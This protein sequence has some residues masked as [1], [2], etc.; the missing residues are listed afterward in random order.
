MREH[1]KIRKDYVKLVRAGDQVGAQKILV[2][3][4]NRKENVPEILEPIQVVG[5]MDEAMAEENVS[6]VKFNSL[7]SLTKIN[8]IGKKTVSDIKIM[9]KDLDSL[10]S[11]IILDNVALRDDIVK[12]LREE[13][14]S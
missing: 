10:R 7:D 11:A 3:I 14:I 1:V 12:K 13:L 4:W 9:F 6:V 5:T 2:S 8:G